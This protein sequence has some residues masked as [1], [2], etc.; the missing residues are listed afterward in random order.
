[1]GVDGGDERADLGEGF[2][3][4]LHEEDELVTGVVVDENQDVLVGARDA[5]SKRADYVSVDESANVGRFVH[6]GRL[7]RE[8]RCVG[9]HAV[10]ARRTGLASD[11]RR[12]VSGER[13][14]PGKGARREMETVMEIL[15]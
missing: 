6:V 11:L 7:V 5:R 2:T 3:L 13:G 15:M 8:P 1:M 12:N 14:E 4:V 9:F 10:D